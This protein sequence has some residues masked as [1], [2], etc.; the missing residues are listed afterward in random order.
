MKEDLQPLGIPWE[1][2]R[3]KLLAAL[4][5]K[6]GHCLGWHVANGS[7]S[8]VAF[9]ETRP[10]QQRWILPDG[11]L[12][13]LIAGGVQNVLE[14]EPK[15]ERMLLERIQF[16]IRRCTK[17]Q[18]AV[19]HALEF[20]SSFFFSAR[21][22][23]A[24][25]PAPWGK[26][27]GSFSA[28]AEAVGE[29]LSIG[30]TL[31]FSSVNFR[32]Y[33]LMVPGYTWFVATMMDQR[34]VLSWSYHGPIM[35][36]SWSYHGPIMVLSCPITIHGVMVVHYIICEALLMVWCV[37]VL[38]L[39]VRLQNSQSGIEQKRLESWTFC[40]TQ[41]LM[42]RYVKIQFKDFVQGWVY[43]IHE[44]EWDYPFQFGTPPRLPTPGRACAQS[45]AWPMTWMDSAQKCLVVP[46]NQTL[47]CLVSTLFPHV[48][49]ALELWSR[50]VTM[51]ESTQ[52]IH[53]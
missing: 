13:C 18:H 16:R 39:I 45:E 10:Y 29:P 35:V 14:K 4:P 24:K 36:L 8:S 3:L 25:S 49:T 51:L 52:A 23:P 20:L 26:N 9:V 40:A 50:Y 38:V 11:I 7:V 27:Q 21:P 37:E 41:S 12:G 2:G 17:M 53:P 44:G 5:V 1:P 19:H 15:W 32:R 43:K 31:D 30:R 34:T 46:G 48:S 33:A 28:V 47:I 6:P 42:L 22:C